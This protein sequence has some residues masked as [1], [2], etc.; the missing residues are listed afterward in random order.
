MPKKFRIHAD[1]EHSYSTLRSSGVTSPTVESLNQLRFSGSKALDL[2]TDGRT[3][4]MDPRNGLHPPFQNLTM[5]L[6]FVGDGY[7]GLLGYCQRLH[8]V[9]L[10]ES[11][12][13]MQL[14]HAQKALEAKHNE[15]IQKLK[16]DSLDRC[17]KLADQV[18]ELSKKVEDQRQKLEDRVDS[19]DR[20]TEHYLNL[21]ST[22]RNMRR[23][24][25]HF[26]HLPIGH[27][28]RK[29]KYQA[30][31]LLSKNSGARK[32]RLQKT[33][34]LAST[35]MGCES[36]AEPT[37]ASLLR[38]IIKPKDLIQMINDPSHAKT[39]DMLRKK[40]FAELTGI[41]T[42]QQMLDTCDAV[43]ISRKG[44][45]GIYNIITI[46]HREK[47][48]IR[49]LLPTPYSIS[50]SKKCANNEVASML[51]GFKF[52]SAGM[53]MGDSKTFLYN[54]FNNVY[55]DVENLQVS[56][57]KYYGLTH[58]ECNGKVLFVMKLDEC[59]VVKGQ[60]LERVSI[61]LMSRALS[62]QELEDDNTSSNQRRKQEYLG[63]QS[64]KNHWWLA[65]FH[66]PHENHDTLSWYF[67]QTVIPNIIEQ[68]NSGR[69]IHVAGIGV[70]DVEWHL[71]GDLKTLKCM[72]GCKH[73]ANTSF[74]CIYCCQ[75]RATPS[76]KVQKGK[77]QK[78]KG[79]HKGKGIQSQGDW[80]DGILSCMQGVPPNRDS[81]DKDWSPILSIPLNRVHVCTLHA[82]LRMLDKLL[83]LHINYAWNMEPEFRRQ[84]AIRALESVLSRVGLHGG[85][86]TLT[87]DQKTSGS[88]QNNPQKICM[89]GAK[90]R[91]LLS[92]HSESAS[93]T[94][95][96]LWKKICDI[97]TYKGNDANLGIKRARVWESLDSMINL[98]E[99]ASLTSIEVE[100]LKEKINLFTYQMVDAWGETHITHYMVIFIEVL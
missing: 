51:G 31:H 6:R 3:Y 65:A 36:G 71:A 86:V 47:G 14:M 11:H 75:R 67:H 32:R 80:R 70:F 78:G 13:R 41:V 30:M 85:A 37:G 19:F 20:V 68:Q 93:H 21:Q 44:Y 92:N 88:T 81:T 61:T 8:G 63:V 66:L 72:L 84:E 33:R 82:R 16:L 52:V 49:P 60:R 34:Y 62:G 94:E 73:G 55:V 17:Q 64:E 53:P 45:E 39:T 96:E 10:S 100:Q 22:S 7:G 59:Q 28:A 40:F 77:G 76:D 99:K 95:F 97:T 5:L 12:A 46:G 58:S 25:D 57:I 90:A 35:I 26:T 15:E 54:E 38:N 98:L 48:L 42:S 74:P 27:H 9:A 79:T 87:K 29:R 23:R 24:I 83:K 4:P 2:W 56:M 18:K 89:G 69:K 50:M 43:G 91:H 1:L